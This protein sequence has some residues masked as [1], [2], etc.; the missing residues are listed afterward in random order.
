MLL[1]D[2]GAHQAEASAVNSCLIIP[3]DPCSEKNLSVFREKPLR[4]QR[5]N[6]KFRV[7]WLRV[8][9]LL[10]IGS[11]VDAK[12]PKCALRVGRR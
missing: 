10:V 5:R 12:A 7:L 4:V 9:G 3:F 8:N 6:N 1:I 11:R 2:R